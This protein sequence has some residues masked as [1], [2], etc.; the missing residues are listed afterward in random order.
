MSEISYQT[1]LIHICTSKLLD[2]AHHFFSMKA[3]AVLGITDILLT[4]SAK[5]ITKLLA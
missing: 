4:V 5:G 2:G 3:L 1:R